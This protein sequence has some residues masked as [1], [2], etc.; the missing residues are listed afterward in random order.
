MTIRDFLWDY[1]IYLKRIYKAAIPFS[2][3]LT[4]L[5]ISTIIFS[6]VFSSVG[7]SFFQNSRKEIFVEGVVGKAERLNPLF[8]TNNQ[9]DRDVQELVFQKFIKIDSRGEA[10]PSIAKSWIVSGDSKE[11]TFKIYDNLYWQ[12]GTKL[13]ANDVA[14]TFQFAQDI[15]KRYSIET[16][17]TAISNV[18]V[19]DLGDYEVKFSLAEVNSTFLETISVY[20]VPR[21]ILVNT[22]ID[23]FAFEQFDIK[24]LGSG[25][26]KISRVLSDR[27][28]FEKNPYLESKSV[29][30]KFE[31]RFFPDIKSLEFAFRSNQ[32][33]GFGTFDRTKTS[34]VDE[35]SNMFTKYSFEIPFRKKVIFFNTRIPKFANSS[36]RR[37]IGYLIDKQRLITV[38]NIDGKVSNSSLSEISWAFVSNLDYVKYDLK[39]AESELKVAGYTK[40]STNGFYTSSDGKILSVDLTYLENDLNNEIAQFLSKEFEK[41]GVLLNPFPKSYEQITKEV[42]ASRDFEMILYELEISVDPDQYN[43]WHSLKIDFPNLN[44]SGYKFN[45]VDVYLERGRQVLDKKIRQEN[46]TNFQKVMVNDLPAVF[47]YEPK[48]T[49]VVR[50]DLKGLVVDNVSFPQQRFSNIINWSF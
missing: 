48:Y 6:I 43:L 40:S 21:H 5:L 10:L 19:T 16:I 17:G 28:E 33:D 9:V 50:K 7:A 23:S 37:G 38:L 36:I 41:E 42:L 22:N 29:I 45:R 15:S 14:F 13:T 32:I 20:I 18:T 39:K 8:I 27:I 11:Y 35:Y 49:Y 26:Y 4:F 2:H 12:D 30:S 24:P 44:V 47:L 3:I 31:Y 25:P 1:P 34:F 46:Y